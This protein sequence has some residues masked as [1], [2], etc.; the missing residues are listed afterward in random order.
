MTTSSRALPVSPPSPGTAP[1]LYLVVGLVAL[2]LR[3]LHNQSLLADPLYYHPLGGNVPLLVMAQQIA[4]GHLLPMH[5]AFTQNSPAYPYIVA[6]IFK[7]FGPGSYYAVRL[8]QSVVDAS[9]CVLVAHLALRRFGTVAGWSAGILMAIYGPLIFFSAGLNPAPFTVFLV[10]AAVVALD[11]GS[12]RWSYLAA[13]LLLGLGTATHPDILL[14]GLLAAAVP[15]VRAGWAG[16]RGA[17]LVLVG[18]FVGLSPVPAANYAA[19]GRFTLLTLSGGHNLYIGHNP[20]AQA[21]YSLPTALDGDIFQTMKHLAEEVQGRPMSSYEVS[22]Y[23]THKALD[24]IVHHP[25]REAVLLARRALMSVNDFEATTYAN[26]GYQRTYSPVLRWAPTFAVLFALA[27]P[28]MLLAW[29]R[30]LAHLWIPVVG[31]VLTL[32]TFFYI[33]RLRITMVPALGVFAGGTVAWCVDAVRARAWRALAGR[34]AMMAVAAAVSSIPLLRSDTS[35]EWNKAGGILRLEGRYPQAEAALEHARRANP[36]NRDV[37][38]NL[39]VLYRAMGKQAAAAKAE[40]K[41]RALQ[42]EQ[43]SED[44]AFRQGLE[45]T[46]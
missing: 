28:G 23:Y 12:G 8:L 37:Y 11:H 30:A 14:M 2:I 5:T 26:I 13:G 15:L 29:K 21:Q 38:L 41:A 32:L 24:Y 19:S 6:V 39:A 4:A 1:R 33:A 42:L 27:V 20:R 17:A 35:N 3:L 16:R 44:A 40:A 10:T 45:R 46:R 36:D 22:G 18:L 7:L 31:S 25:G 9:T 34:A 43:E